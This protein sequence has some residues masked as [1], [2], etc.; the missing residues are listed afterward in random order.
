MKF[1]TP[2][3]EEANQYIK[4]LL[5]EITLQKLNLKEGKHQRSTLIITKRFCLV[6]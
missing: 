5:S 2:V 6:I 4:G 3:N 1:Y